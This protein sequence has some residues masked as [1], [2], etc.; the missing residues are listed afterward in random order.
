MR[1]S[2]QASDESRGGPATH[3]RSPLVQPPAAGS[4]PVDVNDGGATPLH[5]AALGG[6]LGV[7]DSLVRAGAPVDAA[8]NSGATPLHW[9]SGAGHVNVV[10]YLVEHG[11]DVMARAST[12]AAR[13]P[14]PIA[15]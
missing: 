3:S 6:K 13:L 9:A 10:E 7:V 15:Q 14:N 11:A 4:V 8:T 1:P 5:W 12:A 2:Q